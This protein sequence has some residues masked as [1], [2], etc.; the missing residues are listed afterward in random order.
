M[1][2]EQSYLA[3]IS[4]A[5]TKWQIAWITVRDQVCD[6]NLLS[7]IMAVDE[8]NV[9]IERGA[10]GAQVLLPLIQ[11]TLWTLALHGWAHWNRTASFNG[12]TV[13]CTFFH[14]AL[15]PGMF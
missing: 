14:F 6:G 9:K 1:R 13:G 10:N 7:L 11:G 2:F 8:M 12:T 3:S 5:E 4:R 15:L